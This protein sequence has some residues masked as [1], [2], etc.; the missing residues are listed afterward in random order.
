[1]YIDVYNHTQHTPLQLFINWQLV[2][3]SSR[4]H[5]QIITQD[6]YAWPDDRYLGLKLDA[7]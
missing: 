6:I 3:S 2:L 5:H 4:C 7:S 1:M